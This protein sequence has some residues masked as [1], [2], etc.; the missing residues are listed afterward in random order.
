MKQ[1]LTSKEKFEEWDEFD[2]VEMA[3][4]YETIPFF[5]KDEEEELMHDQLGLYSYHYC[6][7][8]CYIMPSVLSDNAWEAFAQK[9]PEPEP[10]EVYMLISL[11]FDHITTVKES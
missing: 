8:M 5:T 3:D 7:E 10:D 2:R 6:Y 11:D 1:C 9:E 4:Y